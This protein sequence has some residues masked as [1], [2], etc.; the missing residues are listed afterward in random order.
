M[1]ATP[2]LD[3]LAACFGG[4]QKRETEL[5]TPCYRGDFDVR[6]KAVLELS[7]TFAVPERGRFAPKGS[8][9][10]GILTVTGI[11]AHIMVRNEQ[12][13][14]LADCRSLCRESKECAGRKP[15]EQPGTQRL[16]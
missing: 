3:R 16:C 12:P 15:G 13:S 11:L 7:T 4:S 10:I 6:C 14:H 9:I 5:E 8:E 2:Y 1:D